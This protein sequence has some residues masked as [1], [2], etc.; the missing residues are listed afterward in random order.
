M[1]YNWGS[2]Q[3][4][5]GTSVRNSSGMSTKWQHIEDVV[6]LDAR[7][8]C[9]NTTQ[10]DLQPQRKLWLASSATADL[11]KLGNTFSGQELCKIRFID[12]I[13]MLSAV[14]N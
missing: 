12:P 13:A 8:R 7:T 10:G 2:G 9:S 4:L 5:F 14:S 3:I 11:G 1:E 6:E